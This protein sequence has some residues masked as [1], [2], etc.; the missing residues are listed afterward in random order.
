MLLR[1]LRFQ[2]RVED[3]KEG[4]EEDDDEEEAGILRKSLDK[5][6]SADLLLLDIQFV[7]VLTSLAINPLILYDPGSHAIRVYTQ[8]RALAWPHKFGGDVEEP[9]VVTLVCEVFFE[10]LNKWREHPFRDGLDILV[11]LSSK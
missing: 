9:E 5:L 4:R 8:V 3:K 11:M 7:V 6:P 1:L 10:L 2:V